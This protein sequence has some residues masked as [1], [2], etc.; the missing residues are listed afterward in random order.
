[1]F[2]SV[3]LCFNT[4]INPIYLSD[5]DDAAFDKNEWKRAKFDPSAQRT[6]TQLTEQL[7]N[8]EMA[9]RKGSIKYIFLKIVKK[10][11]ISI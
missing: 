9:D 8:A 6:V 7:V 3:G 5:D 11:N 2:G 1:M 4:P 10:N